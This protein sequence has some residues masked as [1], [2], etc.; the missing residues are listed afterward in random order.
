MT[1]T[2]RLREQLR[3]D[4]GFRLKP[5]R[6][7]VGKLTIGCGRN[8]DDVGISAAEAYVLL[9]NDI[10]ERVA[11]LRR[12]DW[13]TGLD[14]ARQG[15]LVNMAFMGLPKLLAFYRMIDAL[16]VQDWDRSADEMLNSLWAQQV[17]ARATRLAE[18]M[19]TG[20]WR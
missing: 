20:A 14:E 12:F 6:D 3:R 10:A 15:V 8:L 9:D 11:A 1:L 5:Y 17:G 2:E 4:E 16:E 13:F 18:Q 7:T 19:R